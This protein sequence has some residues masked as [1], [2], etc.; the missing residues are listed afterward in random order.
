MQR[1]VTPDPRLLGGE[2]GAAA[3]QAGLAVP[4]S[5]EHGAALAPSNATPRHVP[6]EQKDTSTRHLVMQ[7]RSGMIQNSQ[8]VETTHVPVT[9][10][11]ATERGTPNTQCA[12]KGR[13]D[14]RHEHNT[15]RE[16]SKTQKAMDTGGHA[17]D[18]PRTGQRTASGRVSP[19]VREGIRSDRCEHR[20]S[21]GR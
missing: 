2:Q 11:C 18:M 3:L 6:R 12:Q 20:V 7:A 5:A 14:G 19:G 10:E 21:E 9:G 13:T 1:T 16:R 17:Q 4:Q 15:P 8:K